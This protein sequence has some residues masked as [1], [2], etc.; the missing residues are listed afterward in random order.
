MEDWSQIRKETFS[1]G[2]DKAEPTE[3][4]LVGIVGSN[5]VEVT[6]VFLL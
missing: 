6:D 4:S 3:H 5:P 2:K 1:Q